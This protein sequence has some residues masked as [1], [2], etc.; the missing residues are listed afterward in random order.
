MWLPVAILS[1]F[2]TPSYSQIKVFALVLLLFNCEA[3]P[4]ASLTTHGF[5]P[6]NPISSPWRRGG[7]VWRGR[8]SSGEWNGVNYAKCMHDYI[9]LNPPCYIWS[10]CTNKSIKRK[11]RNRNKSPSPKV[12]QLTCLYISSWQLLPHDMWYGCISQLSISHKTAS[13]M[14]SGTISLLFYM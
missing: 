11:E 12:T 1:S 3:A 9:T 6:Q 7:E 8:G 4:L 5:S 13:S 10:E 2:K 14:R